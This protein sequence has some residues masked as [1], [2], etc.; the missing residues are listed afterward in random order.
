MLYF[1]DEDWIE[2]YRMSK[3]SFYELVKTLWDDIAP[4][5]TFIREPV[6]PEKRV[7]IA[8]YKICSCSEYRTVGNLFGVH[9]STVKKFL[10]LFGDA[11]KKKMFPS[12]IF[13][14]KTEEAFQLAAT[15]QTK[16]KIPM[17][18][19]F[20]DGSH[21]PILPPEKGRRDFINRK[22]HASIVLQGVVDVN[23]KFRNVSCLV[24]GSAHDATVL[25]ASSLFKNI[26][27][28]IP[29]GT[30]LIEN[31]NIPFYIVGDPAYPLLP[32]LIKGY[33]TTI[34]MPADKESFNVYLASSRNCVEIAFGR[35]KGRWRIL[36]KR[37]DLNF[38]YVP[39]VIAVCCCLHNYVEGR[40]TPTPRT[41]THDLNRLNETY[42]QPTQREYTRNTE[43]TLI[44]DTLCTHLSKNFPLR[45]SYFH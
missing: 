19:G 3:E 24:P 23:L 13:M 39:T 42:P 40:N 36:L 34:N 10:Y 29:R 9:K 43:N 8:L 21:I 26:D 2:N 14:P 35:L 15:T 28:L 38:K 7:A 37:L 30:T 4:C 25:K 16:T 22:Q 31:V 41:M 18:I 45:Q 5:D 20:I 33:P 17:A 44:R 32:W 1:N 11:V 27:N 6:A 12:L